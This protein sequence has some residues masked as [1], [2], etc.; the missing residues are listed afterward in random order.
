MDGRGNIFE[1]EIAGG[2]EEPLCG[3]SFLEIGFWEGGYVE[4]D[5]GTISAVDVCKTAKRLSF[6]P[7]ELWQVHFLRPFPQTAAKKQSRSRRK[8][9]V[10]GDLSMILNR[11]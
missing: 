3:R 6:S 1:K 9:F 7:P 4:H 11:G 5:S 8:V 10:C 2:E